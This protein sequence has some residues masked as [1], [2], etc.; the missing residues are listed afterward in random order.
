V[1]KAILALVFL[2]A[3]TLLTT[4]AVTIVPT[5]YAEED[6]DYNGDGNKNKDYNGDG[7]KN[8]DY[9]GDGNKNHDDYNGDGNKQKAEDESAAAI[10]DCDDNDVGPNSDFDCF[11]IAVNDVEAD[12]GGGVT[13]VAATETTLEEEEEE[14]E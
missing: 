13:P 1:N 4:T 8:K 5:A 12:I 11:G 9:N 6:D 7:N 10:A 2:M 3:G 14:E